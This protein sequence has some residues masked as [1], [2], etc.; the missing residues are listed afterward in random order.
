MSMA[1]ITLIYRREMIAHLIGG[2]IAT[3]A[4]PQREALSAGMAGCQASVERQT[5]AHAGFS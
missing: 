3:A 2:R 5:I 4:I 1:W